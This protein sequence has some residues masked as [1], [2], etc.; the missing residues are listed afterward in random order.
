MLLSHAT[1][2]E[3]EDYLKKDDLLLIPIGSTE[4]HGPTGII[5][6]DHLTANDVAVRVGEQLKAYVAPAI[7]YGMAVHHMDFP[8]SATMKPST[9]IS[10]IK[11]ITE[12]FIHHGFKKIFYVNGHGGNIAP[13]LTAYSEIKTHGVELTLKTINWYELPE[14]QAYESEHFGDQNGFHA[15]CGEVSMTQFTHPEAFSKIENIQFEIDRP[16]FSMPMS[17]TEFRKTFPDGRMYSNPGLCTPEHGQ[18]I[19]DIAVSAA[20]QKIQKIVQQK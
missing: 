18:K 4:Q 7:N 8:G 16:E 2:T 19:L 15:T 12:S 10:Y 5:G 13:L 14:V 11:D 6:T 20:V 17:P 3:V 1:W 9:F